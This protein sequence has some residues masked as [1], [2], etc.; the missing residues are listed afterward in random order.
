MLISALLV[1][2]SLTLQDDPTPERI[3]QLIRQLGDDDI[4]VRQEAALRLER[5]G[6]VAVP[7]LQK[8]EGEPELRA[9]AA[10]IGRKIL[11]NAYLKRPDNKELRARW[12]EIQSGTIDQRR[13]AIK[14][15]VQA[16]GA[17]PARVDSLLGLF[18]ID[19]AGIAG[20]AV[21]EALC[22]LCAPRTMSRIEGR[23]MCGSWTEPEPVLKFL[24]D[25]AE[26]MVPWDASDAAQ[27]KLKAGLIPPRG[28]DQS[29]P[30]LNEVR[31][32]CTV[33]RVA[34]RVDDDA[35]KLHWE[36]PAES[37]SYWKR[38]WKGIRDDRVALMD[39][40]ILHR[41]EAAA[42]PA[43]EIEGWIA[44]LDST[45]SRH[46][47]VARQLL[48]EIP[49][50]RIPGICSRAEAPGAPEGL[51]RMAEQLSLRSRGRILY[52]SDRGSVH[53]LYIMNLDGSGSRKNS[54]DLR[55]AWHALPCD[56]YRWAYGQAESPEGKPAL[57]R[58]DLQGARAP[59]KISDL[60]GYAWPSPDGS[61]L[62]IREDGKYLL[63]I[64]DA[65]TGKEL[66]TG[67]PPGTASQIR[68]APDGSALAWSGDKEL[69]ILEEGAVKPIV[70]ENSD[71][72]Y[73]NF[74]W[75]PDSRSIAFCRAD[76]E[77]DP[78]GWTC[79][80]EIVDRK[81][82]RS[83][84]IA[85]PFWTMSDPEWSP[86]GSKLAYAGNPRKDPAAVEVYDLALGK[87]VARA[88]P[89]RTKG[90]MQARV[91]WMPDGKT[92]SYHQYQEGKQNGAVI[93]ENATVF[94]DAVS[95][96]ILC[97]NR[98]LPFF[99]LPL[100]GMDWLLALN[101]QEDLLLWSRDGSR[102]INLTESPEGEYN[103]AFLPPVGKTAAKRPR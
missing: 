45:D 87:A 3:R 50:G 88:V 84:V 53:S 90:P 4:V 78:D 98:E 100:P 97:T 95:G 25:W 89:L 55:E 66:P 92:L 40:G 49:D 39:L 76:R 102:T 71:V 28:S 29:H 24:A 5:L 31:L 9:R 27:A 46:A 86:D 16:G 83:R 36:E 68:W 77:G 10:E 41:P 64:I 96:A 103:D 67:A 35:R 6:E 82:R 11:M 44:R 42:L 74:E 60:V 52:S 2:L 47:R 63:H 62:A 8:A 57:Y 81:T 65:N 72:Q 80:I 1:G 7:Q 15:W 93:G 14:A 17:S 59:E 32:I 73:R 101:D 18:E 85:G 43:E 26:Y 61:K 21:G 54:G 12:E 19:P 51:R 30:Y 22:W 56:G 58:Y 33:C 37:L 99:S 23:S 91:R 70:I 13:E 75:S 79:R 94:I 20:A 38:W 69:R 48:K 34:F